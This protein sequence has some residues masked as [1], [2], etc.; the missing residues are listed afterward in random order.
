MKTLRN[1]KYI[2]VSVTILKFAAYLKEHDNERI[3]KIYNDYPPL[4]W[5]SLEL[6][7]FV[8]ASLYCLSKDV[9][10]A[11]SVSISSGR[12]GTVPAS[13]SSEVFIIK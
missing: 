5:V 13:N 9:S 1:L 2:T 6:S 8:E 7:V 3:F 12:F 4:C 10:A 11:E